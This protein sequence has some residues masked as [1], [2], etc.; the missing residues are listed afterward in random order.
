MPT[1][2]LKPLRASMFPP[3][4]HSLRKRPSLEFDMKKTQSFPQFALDWW[5]H[6]EPYRI[7]FYFDVRQSLEHI[8]MPIGYSCD[9]NQPAT[10][11]PVTP[12]TILYREHSTVDHIAN[13][14]G[15]T[16]SEVLKRVSK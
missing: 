11:T 8:R 10:T 2:I 5:L 6:R 13:K 3:S 15:V 7:L 1:P 9:F 4:P 16:I 12:I 14:N